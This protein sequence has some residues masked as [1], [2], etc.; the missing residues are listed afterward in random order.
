MGLGEVARGIARFGGADAFEMVFDFLGSGE[1]DFKSF[2][3][4]FVEDVLT[5]EGGDVRV[6]ASVGDEG[7]WGV[8]LLCL[9]VDV[10]EGSLG[11]FGDDAGDEGE[12]V[13]EGLENDD[14]SCGEGFCA[15]G[16]DEAAEGFLLVEGLVG[17][18]AEEVFSVD[19]VDGGAIEEVLV[20]SN[21]AALG[22][23]GGV[24]GEAVDEGGVV[25]DE[26]V[27]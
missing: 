13:G 21:E 25:G 2:G 23:A 24:V 26:I 19:G 12:V 20:L 10:G 5:E 4:D 6:G 17:G 22:F 18:A 8:V 1:S 27:G 16:D 15:S 14:V 11:D 7:I 9:E 3:G